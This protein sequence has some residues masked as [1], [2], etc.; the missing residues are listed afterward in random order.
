M[1]LTATF[2]SG[3]SAWKHNSLPLLQV[4]GGLGVSSLDS[5]KEANVFKPVE[6]QEAPAAPHSGSNSCDGDKGGSPKSFPTSGLKSHSAL[7]ASSQ[8]VYNEETLA[9]HV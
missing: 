7:P 2:S 8:A 4:A 6:M 5:N 3:S 9:S 1:G